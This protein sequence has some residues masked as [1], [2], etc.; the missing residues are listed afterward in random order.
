MPDARTSQL[1]V[2]ATDPEQEAV[3]TLV[4]ELDKPTRQVLI[5][6]K[7]VEVSSTPS[8]EKGVNWSGTLQGQNV[9]F[10]NGLSSG[11]TVTTLPGQPVTTNSPGAPNPNGTL[12][13]ATTRTSVSSTVMPSVLPGGFTFNT[14]TGLTPAIGFLNA[15]GVQAVISFLN[16]SYDAQIVSTPRL[17]TLDN[18]AATISV[19]RE[20]PVINVTAST[21]G[22]SSGS[23][24]ITYSNIGT[25]LSVTP[26]ITAND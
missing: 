5:E 24:S 19:T 15:D 6:T 14:L 20:F 21:A 3:D 12:P 8:T 4:A 11:Q 26:R 9:S 10:G 7:L 22:V 1:V 13:N 2:V 23:S 25:V 16:Q 18:E 17:V